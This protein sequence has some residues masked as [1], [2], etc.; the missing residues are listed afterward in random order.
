MNLFINGSRVQGRGN[1]FTTLHPGSGLPIC[2][3]HEASPADVE[4]A[5]ASAQEGFKKWSTLSGTARGRVLMEASRILR[6]KGDELARL[7]ALDTG[8]PITEALTVDIPSAADALEYFAGVA[9][10]LHGEH[11]QLGESFAYTRREPLGVVAGIGAWNYPLQ[12]AAWKAAPA[13]ACGNSLVYKPSELTPLTTLKLAEILSEAGL[14][15]GV[16]N[17]IQGGGEI[18]KQLSAHP[19]IAKVSV[20]GSVRTGQAVM[21]SAAPTLKHLTLELGGKSPLILFEDA[22]LDQGVS[23][24]LLG[25]FFTQ[26]EICSNGTRVFVHEKLYSEFLEKAVERTQKIRLGDPLD[27]QTQ[28]GALISQGHLDRVLSYIE[29]G[30][31]EGARLLCGGKRPTWKAGSPLEKGYFVE[32]TIFAECRDEMTLVREEIFGPVMSVLPFKGEA[33]V[34]ERANHTPYGLAAG[35]FTRDIQRAHRVIAALNAGTCWINN[36]NITPVEI[37]FGGNKMS[38]L[39]RENSLAAIQHY[40]QLKTVYVEMGKVQSLF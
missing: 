27:P 25:N 26:G 32:P 40:T 28:M 5:V 38:G 22:D 39:G 30:R 11:F 10:T 19:G 36:Y 37:P 18:G 33:E 14:P 23:A 21:A 24:A 2:T 35:V 17:V 12:I 20:T 6:R 7:E 16:F 13:L 15:S 9:P 31:K 3:V 34:I 1:P 8:K 4:L 29:M